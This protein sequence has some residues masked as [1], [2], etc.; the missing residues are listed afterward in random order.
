MSRQV[1]RDLRDKAMDHIDHALGRPVDPLV[2]SHRNRF[3]VDPDSKTAKEY[4]AS[5][6]W[7]RNG[8][9]A[10]GGM[11]FYHVT[12]ERRQALKQHLKEIGD[13]HRIYAA[14]YLGQTQTVVAISAAKAKYSLLLEV[15]DCFCDLPFGKFSRAATVRKAA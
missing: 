5:P 15:S 7:S 12:A 14:T 2:V 3:A 11:A 4:E 1:N 13:Q 8:K 9:G 6:F 10:P